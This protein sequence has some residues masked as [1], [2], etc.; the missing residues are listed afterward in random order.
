MPATGQ[1]DPAPALREK[2]VPCLT[3]LYRQRL[4][5]LGTAPSPVARGPS[6]I[7]LAVS[8]PLGKDKEALPRIANAAGNPIA[9]KINRA[10][11]AADKKDGADTCLIDRS[12]TQ[13]LVGTR[14][15]SLVIDKITRCPGA[16]GTY[17]DTAVLAFDLKTGAAVDWTTMLPAGFHGSEDE[18]DLYKKELVK[19]D[20]NDAAQC[21]G[22][23]WPSLAVWPDAGDGG[24]AF[25]PAGGIPIAEEGCV[26][27][28]VVPSAQMR[29]LGVNAALLDDIDRA[30]AQRVK[31]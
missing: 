5:Y 16:G 26:L 24:I 12:V 7:A 18:A 11:E 19:E 29:A 2:A 4:A 13:A 14:Y 21:D 10:L 28:A 1:G 6:P 25:Q 31:H 22:F 8:R 9:Q 20:P 17:L 15:L 27:S 30:H 3:T 23:G